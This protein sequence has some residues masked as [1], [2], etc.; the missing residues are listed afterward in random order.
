[1]ETI[2]PP[3]EELL[4]T[5]TTAEE[6]RTVIYTNQIS[7]ETLSSD[8]LLGIV[9][10]KIAGITAN[11]SNL[12]SKHLQTSIP[13]EEEYTLVVQGITKFAVAMVEYDLLST[14]HREKLESLH[15]FIELIKPVLE[16]HTRS[17]LDDVRHPRLTPST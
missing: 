4:Q 2:L 17:L 12:V 6:L 9:F 14:P 8:E 16:A 13:S 5:A 7:F 10:G 3:T 1:M 11:I 15:K